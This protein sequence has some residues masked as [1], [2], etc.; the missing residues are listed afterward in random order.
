MLVQQV[1]GWAGWPDA[2][3]LAQ[4]NRRGCLPSILKEP[5][6]GPRLP[7]DSIWLRHPAA[8]VLLV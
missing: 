7:T 8:C 2:S 6:N 5:L 1:N 4:R 3:V